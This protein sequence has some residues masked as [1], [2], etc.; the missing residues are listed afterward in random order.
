MDS[1]RAL[2]HG[3]DPVPVMAG[4]AAHALVAA[5]TV[6]LTPATPGGDTREAARLRALAFALGRAPSP[7]GRGWSG[8]SQWPAS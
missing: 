1:G 8:P 7:G 3:T 6:A 4:A 5:G 2:L